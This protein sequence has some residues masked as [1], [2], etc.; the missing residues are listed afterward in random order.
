MRVY[1]LHFAM[2]L[3]RKRLGQFFRYHASK[4]HNLNVS[5]C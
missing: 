3:C 1:T 2:A 4:R 5:D